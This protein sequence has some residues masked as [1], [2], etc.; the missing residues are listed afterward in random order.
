MPAG[1]FGEVNR[2]GVEGRLLSLGRSRPNRHSVD[3]RREDRL[4][5]IIAGGAPFVQANDAWTP[6]R[7]RLSWLHR[8]KAAIMLHRPTAEAAYSISTRL[9]DAIAARDPFI[10]SVN[11]FRA[12]CV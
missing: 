12:A 7:D 4:D 10:T 11:G 3:R 2:R 8:S 9:F 5:A 6:Y 1:A